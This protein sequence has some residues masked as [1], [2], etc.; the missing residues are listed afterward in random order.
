M[1]DS[2]VLVSPRGLP[3][4]KFPWF[5]CARGPATPRLSVGLLVRL[6][7]NNG[8][9]SSGRAPST[10]EVFSRETPLGLTRRQRKSMVCSDRE[11]TTRLCGVA[12]S[13]RLLD[14]LGWIGDR[15]SL[16]LSVYVRIRN[17]FGSKSNKV[18]A[19]KLADL[20]RTGMLRP[21]SEGRFRLTMSQEL[22]RDLF[23]RRNRIGI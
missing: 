10:L 20:L 23:V 18:D 5:A 3:L 19:R 1:T 8:D 6:E 15:S 9:L 21:V 16:G 12:L 13:T 17:A 2:R 22:P 14:L 7:N 11:R 4:Y